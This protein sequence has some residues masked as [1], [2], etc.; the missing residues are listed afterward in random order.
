MMMYDRIFVDKKDLQDQ[1]AA[2]NSEKNKLTEL[3]HKYSQDLVAASEQRAQH[4]E[5]KNKLDALQDKCN[6]L[7]QSRIAMQNNNELVKAEKMEL[8]DRLVDMSIKYT[9]ILTISIFSIVF[10]FSLE[11]DCRNI[12]SGTVYLSFDIFIISFV[13]K[14][15]F[16][17]VVKTKKKTGCVVGWTRLI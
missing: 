4:E 9:T 5:R 15:I 6:A 3:N 12:S 14:F 16:V 2:L 13:S 8:E 7:E 10:I 11:R 17:F 1:V